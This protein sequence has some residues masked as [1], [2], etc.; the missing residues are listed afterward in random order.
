MR[1]LSEIAPVLVIVEDVHWSDPATRETLGFLVRSL[2]TDRVLLAMTLRSDELHRRHPA[3][4]WLAELERTDRLQ[5]IPLT[6]LTA[7]QTGALLEAIEGVPADPDLVARIHRRSEGNPFFVEELLLAETE[8]SGS[9]LPSTLREILLA[10]LAGVAEDVH[11]VLGVVAVAGRRIDHDLL[12]SVAGSPDDPI[13]LDAALRAAIAGQILVVDSTSRGEEGYAFRHALLAEVAYDELLPGERRRLHREFALALEAHPSA[14]G[15]SKAAY[16][17]ELA[18][19]WAAARDDQR[20]FEASLRAAE[21]AEEAFAFESAHAQL[22]RAL[23]LWPDVTDPEA[24]SGGD[25]VELV[26][27]TATAAYLAGQ[28]HRDVA[29]QREVVAAIDAAEDPVRAA[30]MRERLARYLWFAGDSAG[31]LTELEAAVGMLPADPPSAE[32]ARVLSG[33][34]QLLMLLDRFEES[35]VLC[36][37]AIDIAV[38]LDA[39]QAES[40]ARNTL[41]LD[42]V[43]QGRVAEG[44]ESMEHALGMAFEQA[45]VDDI[46]R[47]Y[48]NLAS[49]LLFGGYPERAAETAAR[50]MRDADA[51]GITSTYGTYIGH[52]AVMI[53]TELGQW[54]RAAELAQALDIIQATPPASRYGLARWV[55]LLV[56]RGDTRARPLAARAAARAAPRR[57][58]RG[59]VSR[60]LPRRGDRARALGGP[61]RGRAADR[62]RGPR[63]PRAA[64]LD[65]VPAPGPPAGGVGRGRH[66]R[67]RP[68]P[69]RHGRRGASGRGG[70]DPPRVPGGDRRSDARPAAGSAAGVLRGRGRDG[71][72]RGSAAGRR[73]HAGHLARRRRAVA[74]VGRPYL[75]AYA[76]AREAEALLVA[77]DRV[78]AEAVLRDADAMAAELGARPLRGAI[79]SLAARARLD[80]EAAPRRGRAA[81]GALARPV[82]AHATRAGG[83]RPRVPRA[84]RTARSRRRCSSARTPPAST[85]RTSWASS[86]SRAARRPPRSPS[87]PAW[88]PRS[89]PPERAPGN[90]EAAVR[91][92]RLSGADGVGAMGV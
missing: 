87:A 51:Y 29:L 27:R 55:P 80:L 28:V 65:V 31:A 61:S 76:R 2:R 32:R 60:R 83:A 44:I 17:A 67:D 33:Y 36:E 71:R 46:G 45:N 13:G 19:H 81:D 90:Q 78:A 77:G 53:A 16:R 40:H 62:D 6:R 42:L 49:G 3:L 22:E 38:R 73:C 35:R 1:R 86:A 69:A 64:D 30:V 10:R 52:N 34:G 50:G 91:G 72:R 48:V 8:P 26:A 47:G 11:R 59:P 82:R 21:A 84:G 25:W 75:T 88:C 74:G 92:P 70:G 15:A 23:D 85:S 12:V 63:G 18:H 68:R 66:R 37:Q 7:D 41:G 56:G 79:A 54:D 89:T 57:S 14:S 9:G 58:G 4:P 5:R 20:A 39:R 43:A 24:A